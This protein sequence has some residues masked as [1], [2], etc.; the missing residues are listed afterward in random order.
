MALLYR[1]TLNRPLTNS[2]L[3]GNFEYLNTEVEARYRTADFTAENIADQLNTPALGQT[4]TELIESNAL[5]A[6]LVRD[7]YPSS[8]TPNITNKASLVSRDS[9]GNFSANQISADLLGNADT[10]SE[11]DHASSSAALDNGVVVDIDQGGTNATT[12][13][14]ARANL[15]VLGTAGGEQMAG[16]L[17][18]ATSLIGLPSL[19]FGVGADVETSSANNGDVWFTNNGMRYKLGGVLETVAKLNSPAFTGVPTAPYLASSSQIA[20]IEHVNDSLKSIH[21][22]PA[23]VGTHKLDLKANIASPTFTGIPAAPTP[24]SA[25]NTTQLATT[26]FVQSV[27]TSKANAAEVNAKNYSDTNLNN[28]VTNL[29][30]SIGLKANIASPTFTGTP[31]A[32]SP[33]NNDNSARIATTNYTVSYVT[34]TLANYYT[35]TQVDALQSKWGTSQKFVQSTEPAGAV[36]GDFWF[37]I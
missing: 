33:A 14:A 15:E 9:L 32:P 2:E 8:V 37:K 11:A 20:T 26:A 19:R 36:D 1:I 6:W 7:L 5:N 4:Q 16:T 10:A 17:K 28:A 22:N 3:D 12:A 34:S 18:L 25:T 23:S 30:T 29:N 27:T 24:D 13:S 35:K 21:S 31:S